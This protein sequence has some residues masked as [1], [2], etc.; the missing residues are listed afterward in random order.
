MAV[1][2]NRKINVGSRHDAHSPVFDVIELQ[3][4]LV[5]G[6]KPFLRPCDAGKQYEED[7]DKSY[8]RL[9]SLLKIC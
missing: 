3:N 7:N 9:L 2:L 8:F 1:A 6:A 5:A 4:A